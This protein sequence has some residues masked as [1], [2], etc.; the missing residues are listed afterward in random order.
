MTPREYLDLLRGRWRI[1]LAGLLLGVA[2]AVGVLLLSPP[3]YVSK[4]TLF[5]S[6]GTSS[7]PSAALD[8]N[9][10]S[11][12]RMQTYVQLATSEGIARDVADSLELDL[13]SD[14]L[15]NKIA[16]SAEPDTVLLTVTVTDENPSR[17]ADIADVL[18]DRFITSVD[19]LEQPAAAE[20]EPPVEPCSGCSAASRWPSCS[21]RWPLRS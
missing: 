9:E 4:V 16:A 20:P 2:G 12:Q 11:I 17:A 19:E 6:A 8:R 14:E 3:Q 7:D 13:T 21:R 1:V 18:A 15:L 10:L 5:V